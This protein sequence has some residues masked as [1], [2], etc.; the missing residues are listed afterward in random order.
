MGQ[1]VIAAPHGASP[2]EIAARYGAVVAPGVTVQRCA[3]GESSR[4]YPVWDGSK[5]IV[6]DWKEQQERDKRAS[7]KAGMA[8]AKAARAKNG[9][10][11]QRLRDLHAAGARVPAMA[12][13]LGISEHYCRAMLSRAGLKMERL[14]GQPKAETLARQATVAQLVAAGAGEVEIGAA[15]GLRDRHSVRRVIRA[16]DPGF[17]FST[18]GRSA[19]QGAGAGGS[20]WDARRAERDRQVRDLV[21]AGAGVEAICAA[22]GLTS[23]QVTRREIRRAC[24]G[25]VF[26][27]KPRHPGLADRDARIGA[28]L[29]T[30]SQAEIARAL[31]L[32][33]GQIS[34]AVN[35]L[36]AAGAMPPEAV[37]ALATRGAGRLRGTVARAGLDSELAARD[38]RIAAMLLRMPIKAVA[39]Q[40][41]LTKGQVSAATRRLRKAGRITGDLLAAMQARN[42]TAPARARAI[43]GRRRD[44]VARDSQI[45]ELALTLSNPEIAARLDLTLS[46][47]KRAVG[48]ARKK[49]LL[50]PPAEVSRQRHVVPVD[51]GA[52]RARVLA[53]QASGALFGDIV[54]DVGMKRDRVAKIIRAAGME[55]RFDLRAVRA[56]R[57]AELPGL[58][59]Q[60][61]SG[62]EIADHWGVMRT[63]VHSLAC[64][65]KVKLN[66]NHPSPQ[67]GVVSARIAARRAL[68]ADMRAK[69]LTIVAMA[70]LLQVGKA[71]I[72]YDIRALGLAGQ[73]DWVKDRAAVLAGRAA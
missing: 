16:V 32:T 29:V 45:A 73:S 27:V 55:P 68:V 34:A 67:K 37:V 72:S 5:L 22:L 19:V 66:R 49:G 56:A 30:E 48:R 61:L 9:D 59:A 4:P 63:Y 15:V 41:G 64:E 57:V 58:V 33:D 44:V 53:L 39:V 54:A 36:K 21:A 8:R 28:M 3:T 40:L 47:V 70:D 25:H 71:V 38:D 6:P 65:A 60:G 62:Q 50:A 14:S 12:L 18:R 10:K 23:L 7:I 17:D 2:A 26:A 1:L 69:G 35:R 46:Q 52:K 31:G 42:T 51:H 11:V 13:A 43:E 24:P 20:R